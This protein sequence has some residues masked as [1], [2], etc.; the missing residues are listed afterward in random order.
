MTCPVCFEEISF[1]KQLP[2]IDAYTRKL[3]YFCKYKQCQY[4]GDYY[5]VLEH[6]K[7]CE[8]GKQELE[9]S[10]DYYKKLLHIKQEEIDKLHKQLN[11][12][13]QYLEA[14]DAE[15]PISNC[16]NQELRDDID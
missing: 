3:K 9:T 4:Q 11:E 14:Q 10:I 16:I 7:D 13:V 1:A 8:C 6:M 12:Q 2:K 15:L 5:E